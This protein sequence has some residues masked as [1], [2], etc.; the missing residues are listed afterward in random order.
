MSKLIVIGSGSGGLTAAIGLAKVG[1]KVTI[2]EKEYIGGDCTNFGCIP[3]KTILQES[4]KLHQAYTTLGLKKDAEYTKKAEGVL[5][6]TRTVVDKF[7]EHESEEWLNKN[8][9]QL[10]R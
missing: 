8:G 5:Q 9:V 3:S 2:I 7:R 4:K 10:V 1:Y 6:A